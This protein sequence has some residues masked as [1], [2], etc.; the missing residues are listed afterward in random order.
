MYYKYE[1]DGKKY[2]FTKDEKFLHYDGYV[3]EFK[4]G[5]IVVHGCVE[6]CAVCALH[7]DKTGGCEHPNPYTSGRGCS[8]RYRIDGREGHWLRFESKKEVVDNR[9][10][11]EKDVAN[12]ILG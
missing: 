11:F 6:T 5:G 3:Y 2:S 1:Y 4:V 8:R 7:N 9:D 10:E 12:L